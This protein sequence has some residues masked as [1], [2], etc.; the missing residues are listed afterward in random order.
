MRIVVQR[1]KQASVSVSGDTAGQ[2]G[3]GLL[4]L[5]GVAREDH[6]AEAD[7]LIRKLTELRIFPDDDGKMNLSVKE[8]GGALLVVSQFTLYADCRRGRR[9]G[10]DR[11]AAPDQAREL[12]EYFVREAGRSG[13]AVATGVFQ[14]HMEV[15]L[16]NDGPVTIIIDSP[17]TPANA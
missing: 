17:D 5:L 3:R 13:V 12:Y 14:A 15:S 8:A 7:Y 16:V 1:V 11:A 2:I 4:V 9:P 6:R 10:F